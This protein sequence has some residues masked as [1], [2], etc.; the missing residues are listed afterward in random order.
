[1][2]FSSS[3]D[4]ECIPEAVVIDA[5]FLINTKPLRNTKTVPQYTKLL[6]RRFVQGHFKCGVME[7]HIVFD[8]P[9]R[10]QFNPK[11]FEQDVALTNHTHKTF[12][13]NIKIDVPW[14]QLLSCRTCK[15]NLVQCTG[16]CFLKNSRF[17]IQGNQQIVLSGCFHHNNDNLVWVITSTDVNNALNQSLHITPTLKKLI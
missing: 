1:M 2:C 5:M 8:K 6:F 10:R 16:Q 9:A 3:I 7:I 13:S 15:Y 12:E 11:K 4:S 14:S 17:W